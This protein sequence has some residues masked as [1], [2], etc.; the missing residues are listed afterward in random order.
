MNV[1]PDSSAGVTW[2]ER[3]RS[4]SMRASRAISTSDL[5]SASNTV[6]TTRLSWAATAIPTFTRSYSSNPPSR[7][8]AL[9]RG[10]SRSASPHALTTM[11]L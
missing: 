1:P 2:R 10:C 4:A 8:A 6:G 3:T 9:A 7:Y 11:S 5:R